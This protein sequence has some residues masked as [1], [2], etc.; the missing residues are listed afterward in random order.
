MDYIIKGDSKAEVL[1]DENCFITEL[2][3]S[4]EHEQISIAKARVVPGVTT[5]LHALTGTEEYYYILSGTGRME[6]DSQIIGEVSKGDIVH[7]KASS[8][9]RI[10]N[11]GKEDLTFICICTPRFEKNNYLVV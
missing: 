8:P 10:A 6:V 1:T 4:A 2:M 5:E 3:N 9:Q 7:I 11:I